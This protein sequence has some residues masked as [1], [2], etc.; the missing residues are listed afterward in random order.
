MSIFQRKQ[1]AGVVVYRHND[2]GGIEALLISARKF[3]GS[4]VLPGG[5]MEP[6][7]TPQQT[8]A[9]ECREESGVLIDIGE[10]VGKTRANDCHYTFYLAEPRGTT[11]E[12]EPDRQLKWV[13]L[14]QLT[15]SLPRPFQKVAEKAVK[16]IKEMVKK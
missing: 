6:G 4:W 13:P 9:R 8:A 12:H 7:E 3:P 1:K 5:T 15:A 11:A 16:M 2:E 14:E 10:Y